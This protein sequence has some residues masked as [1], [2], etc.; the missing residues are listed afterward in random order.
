MNFRR[1][2][3]QT[4]VGHYQTCGWSAETGAN[5]ALLGASRGV[6]RND[7]SQSTMC[8]PGALAS[9]C[10]GQFIR[11]QTVWTSTVRQTHDEATMTFYCIC[12]F[13]QQVQPS[14]GPTAASAAEPSEEV[15][16]ER[17]RR[18]TRSQPLHFATG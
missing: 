5:G 17:P 18:R 13:H 10:D 11:L 16:E 12:V 1:S 4:Y 7:V 14:S 3:A 8:F 9:F 15:E 6:S 2:V